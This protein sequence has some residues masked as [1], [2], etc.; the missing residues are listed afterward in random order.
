[1]KKKTG[2]ILVV[3]YFVLYVDSL[4]QNII[5]GKVYN[6]ENL[7]LEKTSVVLLN[8]SDF[9]IT[10]YTFT[11]KDGSYKLTSNDSGTF[12]LKFSHLGYE[13]KII[14]IELKTRQAIYNID[15]EMKKTPTYLDEVIIH[16]TQ[17]VLLKGD[18]I[19]LKTKYF[20]DG[21]EQT[22]EELLS[23][24]PGINVDSKGAI[25]VGNQE[26][27]KLM[28]DGDDLLEKG[29]KILSKN[30]PAYPIEEIEIFKSFSNNRLLK[31]IEHSD[32]VALNLKLN[33]ESKHI[34]FGNTEAAIGNKKFYQFKGNLMNFG[35]RNK[36]YFF[37]NLNNIGFDAT[38]DIEDLIHPFQF[39]QT[40]AIGDD[41]TFNP[42]INLTPE[43]L[44]LKKSRTKFNNAKLASL[45]TVFNITEKLKLKAIGFFNGDNIGFYRKTTD[46]VNANN[47][48]FTNTEDY[49]LENRSRVGFGKL[50][51]Y[52]NI[53]KNQMLE[54]TTRYNNGSFNGGSDLIFNNSSI[55]ENLNHHNTLL[56]Q[57]VNYSNKINDRKVFTFTGRLISEKSPQYYQINQFLF[58]DLFTETENANNVKQDNRGQMQFIGLN[59]HL[60]ERKRKGHL[61]ELQIGNELRKDKLFTT[62]SL[63]QEKNLLARP[64]EYQN[65]TVYQVNDLYFKAKYRYRISNMGLAPYINFHQLFNRL[66]SQHNTIT[67]NPFFVNPG[68][69]ID[70]KI[71]SKNH[72]MGSYSLNTTNSTVLD[73]YGG[74]VMTGFRSFSKGTGEFNQLSASN[75]LLNYQLGNWSDRFFVNTYLLYSKNH[76]FLSTNSL[77]EQ[78]FI[79]SE[80][81]LIKNRELLSINSQVD[82]HIKPLS[83]NLKLDLGYTKSNFKNIVNNSKLR[84]VNSYNYSYGLEIRSG[85]KGVFNYHFGTKWTTTLIKTNTS[86]L[87]TKNVS[88][89][90]LS[91]VLNEK[92]DVHLQTER[93]HF[94]NRQNRIGY[95]FL[96]TKI[97]YKFVPNKLVFSIIGKNLFNT[98]RFKELLVTDI[99][100]STIE[101]R[102]LP[103]H[104]LFNIEYRF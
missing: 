94:S 32:K 4:G 13:Q 86:N 83:S 89:L 76:D 41:Q 87:F 7:A 52:Y 40:A 75:V 97:R 45:N 73:V 25:K 67:Q 70:W 42:L 2:L 5:Y 95:N 46:F 57:K 34:W 85:F 6:S 12:I 28:I 14:P 101:Y 33:N 1:M 11:D 65:Q 30:M 66:E 98:D 90:D 23:K 50:D 15:A 82:Y 88:F 27:E 72:I 20:T 102:L 39:D 74:F 36:Y 18:T 22:V 10:S 26:I 17:P 77:V 71:N 63:F 44:N 48:T 54:S 24:I 64:D 91:F 92:F 60:L 47:A 55:I 9:N 31:G 61:L 58:Q 81:I 79:L 96:D 43:N 49:S 100:T 35:K 62:F 51:I 69:D 3:F 84:E 21:S 68:I 37:T 99:A 53:S 93:Y 59:A 78:N 56:D 16:A 80:K 29:Y 19:S 38:G 8:S 103:F 104:V